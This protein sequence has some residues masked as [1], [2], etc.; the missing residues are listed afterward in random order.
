MPSILSANRISRTTIGKS[1]E[2]MQT[3][4]QSLHNDAA[5]TNSC[6]FLYD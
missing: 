6:A 1:A 5:Q 3:I 4:T 2:V